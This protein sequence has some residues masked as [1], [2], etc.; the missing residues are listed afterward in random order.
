MPPVPD[1]AVSVGVEALPSGPKLSI[2]SGR[3]AAPDVPGPVAAKPS[4]RPGN[5]LTLEPPLSVPI[6]ELPNVAGLTAEL[7]S[8]LPPLLLTLILPP[9]VEPIAATPRTAL[10]VPPLTVFAV[11]DSAP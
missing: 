11:I 10:A 8:M 6:S 9:A 1:E 5:V 2:C 4:V 7:Q 3:R